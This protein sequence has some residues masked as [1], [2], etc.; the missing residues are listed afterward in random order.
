MEIVAAPTAD[1]IDITPQNFM[2]EVIE[3]SRTKGVIVQF[4]APWCGPCKQ[5]GPLLET[6]VA[7]K[8]GLRLARVNIDDN[9]EIAAQLR[10]QSVPTVYGI[11][12]GRPV[13][14]F[15]G[16]QPESA[17][18]QFIEKVA[19]AAARAIFFRICIL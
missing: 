9:P 11:A 16:A 10:V 15:T 2:S 7:E 17:I 18:R 4:W 1:I 13:D 5:L 8:P 19:A 14:A 12:D 6:I 3:T